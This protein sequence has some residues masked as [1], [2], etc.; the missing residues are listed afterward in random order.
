[1]LRHRISLILTASIIALP[2]VSQAQFLGATNSGCGGGTFIS[3][4]VWSAAISGNSL[5]FSI[6][7]TSDG[8]MAYNPNSAFTEIGLG[9]IGSTY[10]LATN[11]FSYSGYGSWDFDSNVN[12]F[13]GFG[14]T[15]NTFGANSS[16]GNPQLQGLPDGQSVTF[17]FVFTEALNADDFANAQV[18]LHDQ[19]GF[20]PCGGS[21]KS[22][23]DGATGAYVVGNSGPSSTCS[24][25][26]PVATVP[27][28]SS[29]ALLGTGLVGLIP[30]IR[31]K[32]RR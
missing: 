19:G 1:M 31:R 16:P 32:V 12:G 6:T 13:N 22:V 20:D 2:T 27:E 15:A 28:P 5:M 23:F 11:G 29:M 9:N 14:L 10:T 8:A 3:C 18:A 25:V 17:N 26:P 24:G 7:N 30:M 4:A 21:S